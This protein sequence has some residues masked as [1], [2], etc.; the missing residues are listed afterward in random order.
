MHNSDE[1]RAKRGEIHAVAR[2][3]K[4]EKPWALGPCGYKEVLA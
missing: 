1:M 3:H 4:A 2:R